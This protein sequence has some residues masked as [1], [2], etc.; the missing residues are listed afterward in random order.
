MTKIPNLTWLDIW[1]EP[2]SNF[3]SQAKCFVH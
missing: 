3:S 2:Q 1:N